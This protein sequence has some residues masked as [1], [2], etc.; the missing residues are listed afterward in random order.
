[1]LYEVVNINFVIAGCIVGTCYDV[2]M[3]SDS[4]FSHII[5]HAS[6]FTS[7]GFDFS[8]TRDVWHFSDKLATGYLTAALS[9][10][11]SIICF[12]FLCSFIVCIGIIIASVCIVDHEDRTL[13]HIKFS[14]W[15][16]AL[17]TTLISFPTCEE[18]VLIP[19]NWNRVDP[20]EQVLWSP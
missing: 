4:L 8:S 16:C 2:V 18:W 9:A 15:A 13:V 1:M 19:W 6:C 12:I 3:S 14:F 11:Y 5:V 7:V 20:P 17:C 10:H